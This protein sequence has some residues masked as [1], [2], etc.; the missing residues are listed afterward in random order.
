[1]LFFKQMDSVLSEMLYVYTQLGR[2]HPPIKYFHTP[3]LNIALL[4]HVY[5][6]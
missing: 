4:T 2:P 3:Q 5:H 6:I 1:M